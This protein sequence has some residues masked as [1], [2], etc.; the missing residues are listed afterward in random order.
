[1]ASKEDLEHFK[2][3]IE[4]YRRSKTVGAAGEKWKEAQLRRYESYL[5]RGEVPPELLRVWHRKPEPKPIPVRGRLIP[6]M[7]PV[8]LIHA[9]RKPEKVTPPEYTH[10]RY[11][12]R[13]IAGAV[14]GAVLL[15]RANRNLH[16][17]SISKQYST[18]KHASGSAGRVWPLLVGGLVILYLLFRR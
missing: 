8:R 13:V 7:K 6:V 1:M 5:K 14:P 2:R 11:S 4:N 16:P 10:R 9:K 17:Y 18:S 3:F 15:K 12:G